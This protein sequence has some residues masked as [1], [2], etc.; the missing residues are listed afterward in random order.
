MR[1]VEAG[2]TRRIDIWEYRIRGSAKLS[3]KE[4]ERA[5]Y[6]YLG[7]QRTVED[8][9]SARLALEQAYQSAGYQSIGVQIPPQEVRNGIVKLE[10]VEGTVGRLRVHGARYFDLNEIKAAAPSLAEGQAPNFQ[11]VEREIVALNQHP[12]RKVTPALRAGVVPGTVDVDLNVEDTLPLHGSLELNNRY[13]SDTKPLRLSGSLRYDNLWQLGHSLGFSF[14][15]AP[16]RTEDAKVLSA[17]YLA[18]IPDSPVSLQVQA[19]KQDSDVST[20]GTFDVAGR[21]D[22]VGLRA[23]LSLPPK[24]N[25]YHNLTL[26]IDYKK[27]EED[28]TI[29]GVDGAL[30]TPITYYPFSAEYSSTWLGEGVVTQFNLGAH[31]H[32]RGLGSDP[33]EWDNKRYKS[34][35]SYLYLRGDLSQTRDLPGDWQLFAKI[36]G[37]FAGQPLLSGEQFGAGGLGTVR[38]YLE[39]EVTADN[40]FGATLELRTPPLTLGGIFDE[41]RLHTFAEWVGLT[42][43]DALPGQKSRFQ[44]GSVG[45]GGRIKFKDHFNG[46][47]DLGVPLL[48]GEHTDKHDVRFTFRLWSEF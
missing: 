7:K 9:E 1:A 16:Q 39:S 14:Q 11:N 5:V 45:A 18:K 36:Q 4:V 44:I 34:G 26:G 38:G 2:E 37:Q 32:I 10:V 15:V 25:Y 48:E 46:S 27:Y 24:A 3:Q 47:I 6:P 13:S 20:L 31:L 28:L 30:Q 23:I 40:A 22:I 43:N 33:A 19:V 21:G 8:V 12:D 35:G 29:T 17:F 42:L 41:F